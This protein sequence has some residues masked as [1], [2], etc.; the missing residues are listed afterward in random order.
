MPQRRA[1]QH[2]ALA[3]VVS[4]IALGVGNRFADFDIACEMDDDLRLV[5]N[6]HFLDEAAIADVTALQ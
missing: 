4:E 6:E 3:G 2:A 1:D 5:A